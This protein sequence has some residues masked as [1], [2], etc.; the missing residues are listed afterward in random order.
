MAR[1]YQMAPWELEA[2]LDEP[3]IW[4]GFRRAMILMQMEEERDDGVRKRQQPGKIRVIS[5]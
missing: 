3:R 2:Q 5:G 1:R 4:H